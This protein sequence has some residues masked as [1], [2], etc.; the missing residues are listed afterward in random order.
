MSKATYYFEIN[1]CNFKLDDIVTIT[2][3]LRMPMIG[4]PD[5]VYENN[6]TGMIKG[7][8]TR[9]NSISLDCSDQYNSNIRDITLEYI[10]KIEKLS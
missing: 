3:E 7:I 6:Y 4:S 10:S 5:V 1:G 2:T 8:S 9:S